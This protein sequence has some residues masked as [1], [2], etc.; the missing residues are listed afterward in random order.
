MD[1][2]VVC[3]GFSS[4]TTTK[5]LTATTGRSKG[6]FYLVLEGSVHCGRRAWRNRQEEARMR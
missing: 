3:I 2:I 6:L 1:G 5:D 4:F